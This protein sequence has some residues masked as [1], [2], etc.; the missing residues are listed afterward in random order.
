M[1]GGAG[2]RGSKD[3]DDSVAKK[4]GGIED[5]DFVFIDSQLLRSVF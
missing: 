1:T 3:L 2:V 4:G 5:G